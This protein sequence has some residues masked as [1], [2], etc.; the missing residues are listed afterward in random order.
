ME[1]DWNREHQKFMTVY[2]RTLTAARKAFRSWPE[3]KREDAIAETIAKCWDSY[4]RLL[5]RG[6][7]PEPLLTGVIRF[8]VLWTRYD[9][10]VAHRSQNSGRVRFQEWIP[11]A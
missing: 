7:D 1:I 10:K 8:S 3:S 6:R 2:T 5:L 9:R 11:A 4:S